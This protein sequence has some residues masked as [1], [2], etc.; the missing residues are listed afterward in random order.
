MLGYG[1]FLSFECTSQLGRCAIAPTYRRLCCGSN[2]RARTGFQRACVPSFEVTTAIQSRRVEATTQVELHHVW[3]GGSS[4]IAPATPSG[5]MASWC[6]VRMSAMCS[7]TGTSAR[8]IPPNE[9]GEGV[10]PGDPK[11]CGIANMLLKLLE[12]VPKN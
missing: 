11:P 4:T 10:N 1:L 7:S 6:F 2:V 8:G 3:S 9:K 12:K 5:M